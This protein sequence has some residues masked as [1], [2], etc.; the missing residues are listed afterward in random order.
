[1]SKFNLQGA[2]ISANSIHIGDSYVYSSPSDYLEKN[3]S[4]KYSETERELVKIIFEN[5]SSDE[6][7]QNILNSLRT[8]RNEDSNID[9]KK[10]SFLNLTPLL[11]TLKTKGSQIALNLVL[12]YI[13]NKFDSIDLSSL[14]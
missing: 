8:I 11:Q 5:T 10:R 7:R 3:N 6:E 4:P 13:E 1:M 12:K 2:N 9:D 14:L